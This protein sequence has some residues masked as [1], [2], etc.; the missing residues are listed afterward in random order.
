MFEGLC[1]V[2]LEESESSLFEPGDRSIFA[3]IV[4]ADEAKPDVGLRCA[5]CSRF[6]KKFGS[7]GVLQV[8]VTADGKEKKR[9]G[10]GELVWRCILC[11]IL[12]R[13]VTSDRQLVVELNT[14]LSQSSVDG[15]NEMVGA[16]LFTKIQA[17]KW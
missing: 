5:F 8:Q 6:Y 13:K 2:I 16:S 3:V 11:R 9:W 10:G 7:D 15:I 17:T 14:P 4:L 12:R 1:P